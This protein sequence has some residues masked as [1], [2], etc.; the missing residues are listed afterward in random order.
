[1]VYADGRVI[2]GFSHPVAAFYNKPGGPGSYTDG[3]RLA[4][5]VSV[6]INVNTADDNVFYANNS[7][8]ESEQG[9]FTDGSMT[10]GLDGMH[11]DVER[12]VLGLDA[13]RSVEIGG[14][15]IQLSGTGTGA[16]P[17]ELGVGFVVEFKS[18]GQNI[19]VPYYVTKAKFRQGGFRANTR[20]GTIDWQIA[21]CE[22]D[23]HRDDTDNHYWKETGQDCT[24]ES[25]AIE[26]L[27]A[28]LAVPAEAANGG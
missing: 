14:K 28:L 2:T 22:V 10:L 7:A 6:D 24:T 8:A 21:E 20:Q 9:I 4:R 25:E 17:P 16:N 12:R 3:F 19:Y 5:G 26:I 23:L 1:M 18:G 13:P 27:E 15:T 11:P